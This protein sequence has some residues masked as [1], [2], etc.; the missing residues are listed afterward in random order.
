MS[1]LSKVNLQ[2][3]P[4]KLF[5]SGKA[6]KLWMELQAEFNPDN[7]IAEAK[8]ELALSNFKLVNKKNL[9]KLMEEITSCKVKYGVPVRNG[10]KI[11]QLKCLGG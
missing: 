2:K 6:W 7:F 4:D 10:K 1:L 8:L 5:P 3:K 11:V 9:P